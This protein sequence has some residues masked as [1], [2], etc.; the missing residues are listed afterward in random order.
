MAPCD[1]AAER[2]IEGLWGVNVA[3]VLENLKRTDPETFRGKL[4]LICCDKLLIGAILGLAFFAYDGYRISDDQAFQERLAE[5]DEGIANRQLAYEQTRMARE[6]L[7]FVLDPSRDIGARGYLISSALSAGHIDPQVAVEVAAILHQDGVDDTQ[8]S[9]IAS[10]ALPAA[11][12]SV[13]AH[14][15]RLRRQAGRRQYDLYL[16]VTAQETPSGDYE[17]VPSA[18]LEPH[19]QRVQRERL[20]WAEV[21]TEVL[22]QGP[23]AQ[24]LE[25]ATEAFVVEHISDLYFLLRDVRS[26]AP[27]FESRSPTLRTIGALDCVIDKTEP[28]SE[29]VH[30][31]ARE[32]ESADLSDA[33]S[34]RYVLA[35]VNVLL[36]FGPV[37]IRDEPVAKEMAVHLAALL[38]DDT[39]HHRLPWIED[40]AGP[41]ARRK[42]FAESTAA[43]AHSSL[44][45]AAGQVLELLGSRADNAEPVLIPF[46]DRLADE[47]GNA[48]SDEDL[49]H[50]SARYGSDAPRFVVAVLQSLGTRESQRAIAKLKELGADKLAHFEGLT[51]ELYSED[52]ADP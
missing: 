52:E 9:R 31:L 50:M 8:V 46:A 49:L 30:H 25:Y 2:T 24:E 12:G 3:S 42:W 19:L 4:L 27:L 11:L 14:A 34:T 10:L 13:A 37:S 48:A 33:R 51:W 39:F 28:T 43:M 6:I 1:F 21:L 32:F 5:R 38:V 7:P 40:G 15:R 17:Y 20:L 41:H 23:P 44:Q 45:F 47:I 29:A 36:E 22:P 18:N 26:A 35:I 16:H